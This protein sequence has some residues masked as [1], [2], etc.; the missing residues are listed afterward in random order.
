[1]RVKINTDHHRGHIGMKILIA[2]LAA[3]T[4][5]N[6]ARGATLEEDL[7][8]YVQIFNGDKN[9]HSDAADTFGW[10][11]LSDPRLFDII[12]RRLLEEYQAARNDRQDKN[13]VARYIRALGFSGQ[14]KYRPT[15]T[16][17]LPDT[18]YQRFA[19]AALEDQ[20]LYEKWNPIISNRASFD[21]KY[22]DDVNR[23][24]NM[25]RSDDLMLKRVAAK[26]VFFANQDDMLLEMLAKDVRANYAITDPK[27]SDAVAWMVKALG[28]ARKEQ[29]KPLLQEVLAKAK[30]RGVARHAKLALDGYARKGSR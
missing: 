30:D 11:G 22:S 13:R 7:A 21:P 6:Y 14:T 9:L 23:V 20:P 1:M 3:L 28:N 10:M 25:L 27:L 29:Y 19:A 5:S 16:K 2:V 24:M 12:E 26:R 15:L 17:L 18:I 8:R 4:V